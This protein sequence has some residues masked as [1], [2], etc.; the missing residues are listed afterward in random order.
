MKKQF[1]V[2]TLCEVLNVSTQYFYKIIK[3]PIPGLVYDEN[4]TNYDE[5]KKF[6]NRKIESNEIDEIE[7][8]NELEIESFD[9]IEIVR[10]S[11]N[12][13]DNIN[14]VTLDELE[15][16]EHYII[17]SYHHKIEYI[18]RN[19]LEINDDTIFVFEEVKTSK[20]TKDKYRC[21][22]SNELNEDRFR[23]ERI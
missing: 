14:K 11:R 2:S 4:Q 12:L 5:L 8:L 18:L 20:V 21:L 15:I 13:N 3:K 7:V 1:N 16:D 23:I 19:I 9:D 6:I 17:C 22:T 10:N